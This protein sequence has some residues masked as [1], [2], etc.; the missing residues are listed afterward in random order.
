[1]LDSP[2]HNPSNNIIA[3]SHL[4]KGRLHNTV[5]DMLNKTNNEVAH[6]WEF[7]HVTAFQ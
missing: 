5:G 6:M 3:M 4:M 7:D 2:S 1:M